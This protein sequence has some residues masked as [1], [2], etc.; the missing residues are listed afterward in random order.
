MQGCIPFRQSCCERCQNFENINK[1]ASK[2]LHGVPSNIGSCI[3]KTLGQYS[4]YFPHI[5]CVLQKYNKC[6]V[7][8]FKNEILAA[9]SGKICDVRKRFMVKLWITLTERKNGNLTSYLHWKFERCNYLELVI[10]LITHLKSMA[11]HSFMASWNYWQY[12]QAKRNIIPGDIIMVHDF[13][14]NYLCTHQNECQGLHW[15]H[16]QVTV[17]PTVVQIIISAQLAKGW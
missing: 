4:G 12:K 3:D 5:D 9:N 8:N 17:M 13:A 11:E 7:E 6:R 16:K 2:Y 1:E 14:Q 10:L 15:H